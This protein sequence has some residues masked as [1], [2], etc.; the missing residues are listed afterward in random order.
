MTSDP[1]S[2]IEKKT[3]YLMIVAYD[4]ARFNGFQRQVTNADHHQQQSHNRLHHLPP[5]R[6]H[7]ESN[8]H[9]KQTTCTIQECL[10]EAIGSWT[11][12]SVMDMAC[13]TVYESSTYL[14]SLTHS[15]PISTR[16]QLI[17]APF[18]RKLTIL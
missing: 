10:E 1:D 14:F 18:L 13:Q 6:P 11:Q 7:W 3:K 8:G 9:K 15:D 5:K 4:G 16:S 17:I 2:S 12:Q